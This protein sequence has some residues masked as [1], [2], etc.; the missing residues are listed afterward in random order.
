MTSGSGKRVSIRLAGV[1]DK[2]GEWDN[3]RSTLVG[4]REGLSARIAAYLSARFV[5]L[6]GACPSVKYSLRNGTMP[7]RSRGSLL[8]GSATYAGLLLAALGCHSSPADHDSFS[9]PTQPASSNGGLFSQRGHREVIAVTQTPAAVQ[10]VPPASP[11]GQ[12][13]LQPVPQARALRQNREVIASTFSP[14][15]RVSAQTTVSGVELQSAAPNVVAHTALMPLRPTPNVPMPPA[16]GPALDSG[17]AAPGNIVLPQPRPLGST[18]PPAAVVAD[19]VPPPAH[20]SPADVP[21]EFE[22]MALP[23]YVVEPP[24]VLLIQASDR[25]TLYLQRINGQHLVAPDGTINLGIYGKIRVAGMTTDQ[26][27]DAIAARL[28]EMMPGL[29]GGAKDLD[30]KQFDGKSKEDLLKDWRKDFSS[31][32]LVKSELRVDVLSYNSKFY[33]V[34]TDGGG[35]GQQVYPFPIT[36]NDMVLDAMAHINGLPYVAN[37]KR[38][39]VARATRAGQPPKIL[40]VDWLSV[41]K[42]GSSATNYQLFPGDR[43]YVDSNHLIKADSFLSKLYSPIQRT[44]GVTLLGASTVNS[45]KLGTLSGS[46]LGGAGLFR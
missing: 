13:M 46:G 18:M 15:Q 37:K 2:S 30:K 14:V 24:D 20:P 19:N 11:A 16:Y 31:V 9:I 41:A 5:S 40:P 42:C 1:T 8:A 12:V 4:V 35:W 44:L 17:E 23:P 45:I 34:I 33:Y 32:A 3:F 25:I 43:I 38:I 7:V 21:R 22:K 10:Y 36:G 6:S 26:I 27:G 39:W 28:L 29:Q